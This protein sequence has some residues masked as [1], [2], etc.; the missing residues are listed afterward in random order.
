MLVGIPE[1]EVKPSADDPA[2]LFYGA[3]LLDLGLDK[4]PAHGLRSR[5]LQFK[6]F[7]LPS[8]QTSGI[9]LQ[10][11]RRSAARTNGLGG[12]LKIETSATAP[13]RSNRYRPGRTV[14]ERQRQAYLFPLVQPP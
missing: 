12:N 8:P 4:D 1:S 14:F 7:E 2:V 5:E 9:E 3:E 11:S 6:H 13:D 10:Y